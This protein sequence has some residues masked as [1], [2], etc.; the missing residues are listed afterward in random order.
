MPTY[1]YRCTEC[2]NAFDIQQAFT[3]NTLTVCPVCDG[4]LR[5]V[6]SPIGVSFSGSGFYRNDSRAPSKSESKGEK[7]EKGEKGDSKSDSKADSG[8]G[9]GSKSDSVSASKSESTPAPTKSEKAAASTSS[10]PAA[11]SPGSGSKSTTP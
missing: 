9:A 8:G 5:K 3:D 7:G 6:F 2:A 1:S 11:V 10:S 4:V